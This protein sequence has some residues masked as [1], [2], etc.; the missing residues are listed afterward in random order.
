MVFDVIVFESFFNCSKVPEEFVVQYPSNGNP[1]TLFLVIR[2]KNLLFL[3]LY[4]LC[5]L[6]LLSLCFMYAFVALCHTN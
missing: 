2:G 6:S 5:L 4:L 3:Y 1:P